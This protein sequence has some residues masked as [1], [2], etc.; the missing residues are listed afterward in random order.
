MHIL[1]KCYIVAV[2][3]LLLIYK[4]YIFMENKFL[5]RAGQVAWKLGFFVGTMNRYLASK[6][7]QA[8]SLPSKKFKPE[9][10][11]DPIVLKSSETSQTV[12]PGMYVYA[13]GLISSEIIEGR[14][15]KAVVGYVAGNT[16]YAVC[17]RETELPWSSD[18]LQVPE[19]QN[20]AGGR[21]ATFKILEA[22][23]EQKKSAEAAQWCYDYAEDGVKRGEACLP[24]ILEQSMLSVNTDKIKAA[25]RR[26]GIVLFGDLY[27]SSNEY[28][29]CSSWAFSMFDGS[30][31][32]FAKYCKVPVRAILVFEA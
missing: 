31:K 16:V 23:R 3:K 17:L 9:V 6:E 26:L 8:G 19:V 25:L 20:M 30:V 2:K 22:A 11:A 24:S 29:A 10:L 12:F 28:D 5:E 14:Q 7:V 27:A 13:N 4:I 15:I 1:S 18:G 21:E 32:Q